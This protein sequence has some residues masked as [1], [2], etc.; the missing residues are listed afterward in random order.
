MT[1]TPPLSRS[2]AGMITSGY[3]STFLASTKIVKY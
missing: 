3:R 2:L 1:P